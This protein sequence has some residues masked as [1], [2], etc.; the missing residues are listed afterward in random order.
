M[1]LYLVSQAHGPIMVPPGKTFPEE[2]LQM[3]MAVR[4]CILGEPSQNSRSDKVMMEAKPFQ[5]VQYEQI[6]S[7]LQLRERPVR[8]RWVGTGISP[9]PCGS[10][11][12]TSWSSTPPE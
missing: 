6:G 11:G 2:Q 8:V 10:A 9:S 3:G 4:C 1:R 12:Q 5:L 7:C